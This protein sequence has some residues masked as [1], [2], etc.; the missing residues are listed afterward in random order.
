MIRVV[1]TGSMDFARGENIADYL[2]H[3]RECMDKLR[4]Q[5]EFEAKVTVS[6]ESTFEL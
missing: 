4:E 3:L 2:E 6:K 1:I 5:G